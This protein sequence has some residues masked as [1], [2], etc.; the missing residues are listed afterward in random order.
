MKKTLLILVCLLAFSYADAQVL[1]NGKD[2]SKLPEVAYIKVLMASTFKGWQA[3]VEYGQEESVAQSEIC[4][5]NNKTRKF[6]SDMDILNFLSKNGFE[7]FQIVI[8]TAQAEMTNPTIPNQK[9]LTK[10]TN[11]LYY[12]LKKVK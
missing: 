8:P 12:I 5:S 4:E 7:L 3:N 1:V 10:T 2:I 6:N 9:T 11:Q